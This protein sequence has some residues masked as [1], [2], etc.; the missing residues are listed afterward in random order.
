[1]DIN[2]LEFYRIFA[3]IGLIIIIYQ[4]VFLCNKQHSVTYFSLPF[5]LCFFV[6]VIE[7]TSLFLA[8]M[9]GKPDGLDDINSQSIIFILYIFLLTQ[10]SLTVLL[11]LFS[12][13]YA[14]FH[15]I[16]TS[17]KRNKAAKINLEES[18]IVLY[19]FSKLS[20]KK[21]Y[22]QDIS[23]EDSVYVM[24]FSKS[25]FFPHAAVIGSKEYFSVKLKNGEVINIINKHGILS[26][27]IHELITLTKVL[28]IK[29]VS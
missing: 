12:G 28:G 19:G 1:M 5:G 18:Y 21:I 6:W 16:Y 15:I 20:K 22:L 24:Q 14:E 7:T 29:Y 10:V 25:K 26:G 23:I 13:P 2:V 27:A 3:F 17:K 11:Y 8:D 4:V 9:F